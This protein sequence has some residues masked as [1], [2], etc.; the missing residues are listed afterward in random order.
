MNAL[1]FESRQQ[2]MSNKELIEIVKKQISELARTGGQ[3]HRMCVPPQV[4]DT[5]MILS[6]M[7]RRFE[8]LPISETL[9]T[10][11]EIRN[12]ALEI[13]GYDKNQPR[14]ITQ[15]M[16]VNY[17]AIFS[18]WF[19][20]QITQREVTDEDIK[21]WALCESPKSNLHYVGKVEGAKAHRDGKIPHK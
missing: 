3:S 5:D 1:E 13:V 21:V 18:K 9:P 6:E 7:V 16:A 8:F 11:T 4:E 12:M 14:L 2:S 19:K 10:K 17:I 20:S 15:E